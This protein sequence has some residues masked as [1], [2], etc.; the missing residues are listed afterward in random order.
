MWTHRLQPASSV[1]V[2]LCYAT[3]KCAHFSPKIDCVSHVRNKYAPEGL[4]GVEVARH[5]QSGVTEL[6]H[7]SSRVETL[8]V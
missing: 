5:G 6:D 3:L 7:Q 4:G 1:H 8:K 2:M